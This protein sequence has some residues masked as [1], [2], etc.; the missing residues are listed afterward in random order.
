MTGRERIIASLFIGLLLLSSFF[1]GEWS[2]WIQAIVL[3]FS[4]LLIFLVWRD[5]PITGTSR[6]RRVW[7]SPHTYLIL[8]VGVAIVT[9]PLSSNWYHSASQVA[10]LAAY[11]LVY[12]AAYIFFRTEARVRWLAY[13][14]WG[15][16]VVAGV[17]GLYMFVIQ[18][19]GRVGGLLFNSNAISSL[20]LLVIPLTIVL[21]LRHRMRKR[22]MFILG[23]AIVWGAF[24]LTY[25]Y[26]AW[27][28]V[29]IPLLLLLRRYRQQIF[30]KRSLLAV[31]VAI[32]ILYIAAVGFRYTQ[33]HDIGRAARV[34]EAISY[35][36]FLTSFSQRLNFNQSTAEIFIDHPWIGTGL[37]TFQNMYGQYYHTVI[38]QPRYAH[39]YYLQTAAELGLFGIVGLGLFIVLAARRIAR[40]LG[41]QNDEGDVPLQYGLALGLLAS[42]IH[43]LF[44]FGWQFPAV[45]LMFWAVLGALMARNTEPHQS[46]SSRGMALWRVVVLFIGLIVLARGLSVFWGA[47]SF[48]AAQL[49]AERNETFEAMDAYDQGLQYDPDPAML[50]EYAGLMVQKHNLL[51]NNQLPAMEERVANA[52]AFLPKDYLMHWTLGR[53]YFVQDKLGSAAE[54]YEQAITRNPV[55]R[56]DIYYDL[57]YVYFVQEQYDDAE[58]TIRRILDQYYIGIDTSNP[59]LPTQLA[60]L[61]Y[62]LG[63]VYEAEGRASL[64][65]TYYEKAVRLDENFQPAQNALDKLYAESE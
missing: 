10:L 53:L 31:L 48:D 29:L 1:S 22:I 41:A 44:D 16:A 15:I 23:A 49:H 36:H 56:P 33:S 21:I 43:A 54:Q 40:S 57:A 42:V 50:A 28:S 13:G 6:M 14:A 20:L 52:L 12:Y 32:L 9:I 17:I 55:F 24:V 51:I 19:A 5:I 38:E 35:N 34:Y 62:L 39:N 27:V 63:E 58:M 11:L 26:T 37:N 60:A 7:R 45:F 46:E 64:A 25:S 4:F 3:I 61:H 30:A 2:K 59:N 18:S 65:Q 8:W 47:Y